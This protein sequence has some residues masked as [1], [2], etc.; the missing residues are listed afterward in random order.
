MDQERGRPTTDVDPTPEVGTVGTALKKIINR[1]NEK[2]CW[3]FWIFP[4]LG[5]VSSNETVSFDRL[6]L[7][8]GAVQCG[9]PKNI[10]NAARVSNFNLVKSRSWP[11]YT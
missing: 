3:P 1:R 2:Q 4:G 7:S 5:A 10:K 6:K 11:F 9:K 8:H